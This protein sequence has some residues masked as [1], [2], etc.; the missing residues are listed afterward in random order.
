MGTLERRL[1]ALVAP[2]AL[3]RTL[4][5][6]LPVIALVLLLII[7]AVPHPVLRAH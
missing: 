5:Y 1:R 2:A 3:S 7:L 4:R 6:V